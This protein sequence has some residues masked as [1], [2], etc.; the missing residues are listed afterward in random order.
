MTAAMISNY[1]DAQVRT[2]LETTSFALLHVIACLKAQFCGSDS[3]LQ[4]LHHHLFL[5][6]FSL[7]YLLNVA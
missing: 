4:N 3:L 5:L 1:V 2:S 6:R 7:Q